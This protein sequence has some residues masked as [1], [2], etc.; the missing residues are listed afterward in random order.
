VTEGGCLSPPV[1][2]FQFRST[3][4]EGDS[5]TRLCYAVLIG[6]I[7]SECAIYFLESIL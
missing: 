1:D 2:F 7:T 6:E 5:E 4:P 3:W